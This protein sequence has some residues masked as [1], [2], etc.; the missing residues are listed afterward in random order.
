MV[1]NI[2][3]FWVIN[4]SRM[5]VSLADLNITIP[6]KARM[7]LLKYNYTL[8][9]LEE[10]RESGSIYRKRDKILVSYQEPIFI[11]ELSKKEISET[12]I[13][14]QLRS[15]VKQES[16]KDENLLFSDEQF[17]ESMLD[18]DEK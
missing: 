5:N 18:I 14:K 3:E 12:P 2:Q 8:K 6:R 1:E 13:K 15:V 17:A 16:G 11:N 7:N 9:E 4:I 10:S